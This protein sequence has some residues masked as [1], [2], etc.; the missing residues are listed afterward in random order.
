MIEQPSGGNPGAPPG[1]DYR[2]FFTDL[3]RQLSGHSHTAEPIEIIEQAVQGS[4]KKTAARQIALI[5]QVR[6]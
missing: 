5:T 3:E 4:F 1:I 2:A 6:S